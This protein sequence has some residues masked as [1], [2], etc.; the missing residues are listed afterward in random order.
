MAGQYLLGV[1]ALL[2][3]AA[4]QLILQ[5]L[6]IVCVNRKSTKIVKDT[7]F[8]CL[9]LIVDIQVSCRLE[10]YHLAILLSTTQHHVLTS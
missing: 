2:W 6:F 9:Q 10:I 8:V 1:E 5:S 4:D 3:L 7:D